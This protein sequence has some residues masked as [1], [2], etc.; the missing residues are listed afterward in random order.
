MGKKTASVTKCPETIKKVLTGR[1]SPTDTDEQGQQVFK[2]LSS[3]NV[4]I[5][6]DTYNLLNTPAVKKTLNDLFNEEATEPGPLTDGNDAKKARRALQLKRAVRRQDGRAKKIVTN[7]RTSDPIGTV[8][9]LRDIEKAFSQGPVADYDSMFEEARDRGSDVIESLVDEYDEKTAST[10]SDLAINIMKKL[11]GGENYLVALRTSIDRIDFHQGS[12]TVGEYAEKHGPALKAILRAYEREG[13]SL[14]DREKTGIAAAFTSKWIIG[15]N[16]RIRGTLQRDHLAGLQQGKPMT[17]ETASGEALV[18]EQVSKPMARPATGAAATPHVHLFNESPEPHREGPD[19]E[20]GAKESVITNVIEV[21]ADILDKRLV[22]SMAAM[23]AAASSLERFT[24]SNSPASG[25]KEGPICF[26]CQRKGL[27][28]NHS[29]V[30]C[31]VRL[32]NKRTRDRA[33]NQQGTP[34][35]QNQGQQYSPGPP[36][37]PPPTHN[38]NSAGQGTECYRCGGRGHRSYECSQ[39]CK[40]CRKEGKGQHYPG[41]TNLPKSR[42]GNGQGGRR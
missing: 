18:N 27:D 38:R 1:V 31:A 35:A 7:L 4:V 17:F 21:V 24:V 10:W 30:S 25:Q 34:F 28:F 39:P 33:S 29:H 22:P 11:H 16:S 9:C 15:L 42:S 5:S 2:H 41:C 19:T 40:V 8:Q 20:H 26:F 23:Q 36:S 37:T 6:E 32:E 13:V 3:R 14:A 12:T